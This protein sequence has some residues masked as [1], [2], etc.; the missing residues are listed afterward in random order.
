MKISLMSDLHLEFAGMELPGGDILLLAGDILVAR[1]LQERRTDSEAKKLKKRAKEFFNEQCSKYN[2]VYYIA[3]N[4]EHY[5]GIFDETFDILRDYIVDTNVKFLENELVSLNDDWNLFAAT[6]WTDYNNNDFW[7]KNTADNSLNDHR[8][9]KK[10]KPHYDNHNRSEDSVGYFHPDDAYEEHLKTIK[11]LDVILR[12]RRNINKNTIVMTHHAPTYKSVHPRYFGDDLNHAYCSN[13]SET[14]MAH[15]N[16]KY[17]F[18][19][20]TH[21]SHDYMVDKCRVIC[22]PRGYARNGSISS[23]ENDNFNVNFELEI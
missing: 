12:E 8:L 14:I 2:Q 19:G 11:V 18:H 15:K 20:H 17:W 16:I 6:L 1:Y 9:I 23:S 4:H 21:D 5:S 3:G 13:L 22:N 7:A 10:V